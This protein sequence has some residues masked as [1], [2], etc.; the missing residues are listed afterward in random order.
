MGPR[1][2]NT[3]IT[4]LSIKFFFQSHEM[5]EICKNT[6]VIIYHSQKKSIEI[7][8]FIFLWYNYIIWFF[9]LINII[10]KIFSLLSHDTKKQQ[11]EKTFFLGTWKINLCT[12]SSKSSLN[13]LVSSPKQIIMWPSPNRWQLPN[14]FSINTT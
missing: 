8:G 10:E 3:R 4:F 9:Y 11:K 1:V 7:S 6:L 14:S 13:F 2:K 5:S 12:T